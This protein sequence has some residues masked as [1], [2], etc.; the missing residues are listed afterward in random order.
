[1]YKELAKYWPLI[2]DSA[3][4]AYPSTFWKKTLR[5]LLGDGRHKIL[6]LGV[7]G[8]HNLSHLVSDFDA[9]AVDLSP[10]MI[11]QARILNPDV[12]L[13]VGDMRTYRDGK[14]YDAVIVDDAISYM[15]THDDLLQ[16]FATAKAHLN[17]GGVFVC[18][19]D[20]L[21]ETMI[22]PQVTS[23]IQPIP[24]GGSFAFVE[25]YHDPDPNDTS[26][27]CIFTFYIHDGQRFQRFEDIHTL[28]VFS[29]EDWMRLLAQAGFRPSFAEYPV[30]ESHE[31]LLVVGVM[32]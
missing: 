31:N 1:M 13:H 8:G 6:E 27:E 16:V 32:E 7:G 23:K 12:E 15:A 5:E 18:A 30:L 17:P 22:M 9:V 10:D 26:Y 19:P 25:Y 11:E 3:D 20:E 14:K 4:Y 21:K 2:S 24:D 28:G 29:K